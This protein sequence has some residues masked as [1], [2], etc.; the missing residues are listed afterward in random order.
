M[1][2]A[3]GLSR[4]HF[5]DRM[6]PFAVTATG[7]GAGASLLAGTMPYLGQAEIT[8]GTD[9]DGKA[10]V[11]TSLTGIVLSGREWVWEALVQIPVLSDA[12][13]SF[14]FHGGFF[15]GLNG[16]N[17]S[18]FFKY[19][20][21]YEGGQLTCQT[22]HGEEPANTAP[23]GVTVV[24]GQWYRLKIV[25]DMVTP[26][27]KYYIDGEFI[28][29]FT[30]NL[31]VGMTTG[32]GVLMTKTLGTTARKILCDWLEIGWRRPACRVVSDGDWSDEDTWEDGN[33]PSDG[34]GVHIPAP[35]HVTVTDDVTVNQTDPAKAPFQVDNGARLLVKTGAT[36]TVTQNTVVAHEGDIDIEDGAILKLGPILMTAFSP[37]RVRRLGATAKVVIG[38]DGFMYMG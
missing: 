23:S 19:I 12:T 21:S 30:A 35:Y 26:V 29:Q 25:A 10:M 4:C 38:D 31:P 8:S 5:T 24:A 34:D 36:L 2:P 32:A 13:N 37:G 1:N 16:G 9:A 28:T 3:V 7:T 27:I 14:K 11:G 6:F 20:H 22:V 15:D 18:A 17:E 33:I